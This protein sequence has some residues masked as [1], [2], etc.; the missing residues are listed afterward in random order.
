MQFSTIV[1]ALAAAAT[2]V[3]ANKV[4][5]V[6]L[7]S[8]VRTI[9]F[10]SSNGFNIDPVTVS[11]S[12]ETTVDF[13]DTYIGNFYAVKE[14]GS[15]A[16][17]MLGE[18]TFGGWNGATYFDVSAIVNPDDKDNV[19]QMW[20]AESKSPISGCEHFPCN[21]AYYLPDDVQTKVTNEVHLITTLGGG[22]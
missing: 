5:F 18:V 4:T 14:G 22:N 2:S 8:A 17:G 3:V 16:P 13:P 6:T 1:M 7:D 20:P 11:S 15:N 12:E 21:D 9:Y 19:K 10:T